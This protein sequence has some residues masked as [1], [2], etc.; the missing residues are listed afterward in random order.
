MPR[1]PRRPTALR[2][3]ELTDAALHLIATEGIAALSTRRLADAVGLSTGAIFRHVA[4]LDALLDAVVTR[5]E[6]VLAE[7]YPAPTLPP[8]ERLLAFATARSTAVGD[9]LGILRLVLS[10]QFLLALPADGS[11]RLAACVQRSRT[12]VLD[13]LRAGQATG[14]IRRDLPAAGLAPIVLGTIQVLAL[15]AARPRPRDGDAGAVL[16]SLRA[17]LGA[18]PP[19]PRS[20]TRRPR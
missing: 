14:E 5:V 11:A 12:Y 13:C 15:T 10:E 18:P 20:R 16:D 8:L 17:L 1:E 4:S 7:T 2:Q 6:A 9:R 19:T 3:A